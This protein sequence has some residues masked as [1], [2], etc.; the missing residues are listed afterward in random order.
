MEIQRMVFADYD[1]AYALWTAIPGMGLSDADRPD[2]IR[3]Y[4]ERNPGQSFVCR[5]GGALIG[6][7]LCGNDGRRGFIHH[8]AVAP[9]FRHQ[10]IG[11]ELARRA[12]AE[13]RALGIRKVHL[14]VFCDNLPAQAFWQAQGFSLRRDIFLMS[15]EV[16][17]DAKGEAL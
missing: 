4:L 3:A 11:A 10:G 7:I 17:M 1:E 9:A 12:L 6:T 5:E 15:G 16:S 14:M 13:Q 2:A 8:T